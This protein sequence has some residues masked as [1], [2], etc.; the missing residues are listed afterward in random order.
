MP[1]STDEAQ[2][3]VVLMHAR[4]SYF[5]LAP[6][7]GWTEIT[8]LDI[9][10]IGATKAAQRPGS[11]PLLTAALWLKQSVGDPMFIVRATKV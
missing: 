10:G 5:A 6:A 7:G 3:R 2:L 1:N 11:N 8:A 9:T 4:T